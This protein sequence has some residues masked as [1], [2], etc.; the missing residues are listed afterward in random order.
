MTTTST[1]ST[2]GSE[3]F[4]NWV[5][6]IKLLKGNIVEENKFKFKYFTEE[7]SLPNNHLTDES[8]PGLAKIISTCPVK[9]VDLTNNK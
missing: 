1:Q 8:M 6:F 3:S 5:T 9:V 7:I 2:T 4:R